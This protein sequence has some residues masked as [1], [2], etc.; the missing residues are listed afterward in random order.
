MNLFVMFV[1]T[2]GPIGLKKMSEKWGF[3]ALDVMV[4]PQSFPSEYPLF[5][6]NTYEKVNRE[7]SRLNYTCV[8][9]DIPIIATSRRSHRFHHVLPTS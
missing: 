2:L 8:F 1:W 4:F 7:N 5:A 9:V 6:P 3:E